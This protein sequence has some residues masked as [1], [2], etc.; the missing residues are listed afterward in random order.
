MPIILGCVAIAIA[1]AALVVALTRSP[2]THVATAPTTTTTV[3]ACASSPT[4]AADFVSQVH[5]QGHSALQ[6]QPVAVTHNG[7]YVLV[8]GPLTPRDNAR[9]GE[10]K[11]SSGLSFPSVSD[12]FSALPRQDQMTRVRI[13]GETFVHVPLTV[14]DFKASCAGLR[15]WL[16]Y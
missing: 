6:S 12:E 7:P 15:A 4:Q 5:Q 3:A 13:G 9:F 8:F 16:Q 11:M 2:T 10:A 14:N 1:T